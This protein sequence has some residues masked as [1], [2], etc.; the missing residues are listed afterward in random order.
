MKGSVTFLGL[1]AATALVGRAGWDNAQAWAAQA[2]EDPVEC[3]RRRASFRRGAVACFIAAAVL[4][5]SGLASL[6]AALV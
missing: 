1:A 5:V 2:W 6:I 4:V 3:E